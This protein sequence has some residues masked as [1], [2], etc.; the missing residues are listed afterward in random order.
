MT[1]LRRFAIA[2]LAA[3][4]VTVGSLAVPPAASAMPM[5]C[6]VRKQLSRTYYATGQFFY[7]IGDDALAYYWWGMSHGIVEGC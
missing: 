1:R 7:A 6:T 4:T 3:A 2:V 5:S